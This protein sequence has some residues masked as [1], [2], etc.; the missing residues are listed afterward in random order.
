MIV[1]AYKKYIW[2]IVIML[3]SAG[4]V[5]AQQIAYFGDTTGL[6]YFNYGANMSIDSLVVD[7][8]TYKDS[9]KD[10]ICIV[11]YDKTNKHIAYKS[12]RTKDSLYIYNYWRNGQL[13][14]FSKWVKTPYVEFGYREYSL[15]YDEVHCESGQLINKIYY[16]NKDQKNV[17]YYCNGNKRFESMFLPREE[18]AHG[19]MKGWY[20]DGKIKMTG[21]RKVF[22]DGSVHKEGDFN[23]YNENGSLDSIQV[24][25][26]DTLIRTIRNPK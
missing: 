3:A 1:G 22:S 10:S 25:K 2:V 4:M 12:H 11:Y 15:Y 18:G 8:Y 19:E 14:E 7:N 20:E 6:S 26:M 16:T 17:V 24:Y 23:Y 5:K 13:K 9:I 21:D